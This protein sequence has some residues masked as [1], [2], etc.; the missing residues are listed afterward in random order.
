MPEPGEG[1]EG[2][3]PGGRRVRQLH[4]GPHWSR[5]QLHQESSQ[6]GVI[7]STTVLYST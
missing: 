1:E 3:G 5:P 4:R 2:E 7:Y 6:V